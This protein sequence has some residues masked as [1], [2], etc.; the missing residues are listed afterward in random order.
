MAD[1]G[2]PTAM[3]EIVIGKL[4]EAFAMGCTDKEAC[5]FADIHPSTL[6]DYQKAHPEF[7]ERKEALKERPFLLARKTIY[8]E[9]TDIDTARWF[10]ERKRKDEFS[11]RQELTGSDGEPIPILAT[12]NVPTHNGNQQNS[13]SSKENPSSPGRDISQQDNLDTPIVDKLGSER[14]DTHPNVSSQ[15]VNAPS[16]TGSDTGLS[17]D[18]GNPPVF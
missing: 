3:T 13:Q 14:Q 17:G 18:N 4:E 8:S 7:T 9:L 12:I 11:S 16:E 2:R 5:T 15:R 1:V 10:M 6:Y